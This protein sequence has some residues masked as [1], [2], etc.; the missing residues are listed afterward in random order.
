MIH[1]EIFFGLTALSF[2]VIAMAILGWMISKQWKV[3]QLKLQDDSEGLRQSLFF[4][5]IALFLQNIIPI[6]TVILEIS[7]PEPILPFLYWLNNAFFTLMV[8]IV[9]L[10][11]YIKE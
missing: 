5:L 10:N 11:L 9:L 7:S 6:F 3:L 1:E 2:R 4:L 8:S